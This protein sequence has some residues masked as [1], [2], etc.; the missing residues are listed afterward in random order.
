MARIAVF[1]SLAEFACDASLPVLLR[2][3]RGKKFDDSLLVSQNSLV[4]EVLLPVEGDREA[5]PF[6]GA[7]AA[8]DPYRKDP[9]S[10]S[11]ET[12]LL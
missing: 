12:S 9:L 6:E 1:T 7:G 5:C 10:L 3:S 8:A 11:L 2:S 4:V